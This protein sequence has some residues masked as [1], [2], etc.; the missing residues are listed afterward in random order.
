MHLSYIVWSQLVLKPCSHLT[1]AFAFPFESS[2]MIDTLA[3]SDCVRIFHFQKRT[4][5][6]Q[7]KSQMHALHVNVP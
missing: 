4:G 1:S 7:P 5:K 2:V 3:K 6:D